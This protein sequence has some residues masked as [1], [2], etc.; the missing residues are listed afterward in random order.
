[1]SSNRVS[2]GESAFVRVE[3]GVEHA[4]IGAVLTEG[5]QPGLLRQL[6]GDVRRTVVP[7]LAVAAGDAQRQIGLP[8]HFIRQPRFAG[9][10]LDSLQGAAQADQFAVQL[11]LIEFDK[12]RLAGA[13]EQHPGEQ[14]NHGGTRG[15][16]QGQART[17]G[18]AA[19]QAP[20]SSST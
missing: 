19:H 17:Q 12:V 7:A 10:R 9:A 18:Q 8:A 20:R 14:R 5:R 6:L 2:C 16:Q 4:V 3:R 13:V 11:L 1:M 15:K